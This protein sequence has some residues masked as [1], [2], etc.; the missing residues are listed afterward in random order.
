[1]IGKV[2]ANQRLDDPRRSETQ[3]G[4][5]AFRSEPR[6]EAARL[7]SEREENF[8]RLSEQPG[9]HGLSLWPERLWGSLYLS[10][11]DEIRSKGAW[12]A[13]AARVVFRFGSVCGI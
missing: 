12:F 2:P 7:A 8:L 5:K 13:T 10:P 11:I 1:M 3:V 6:I 9:F 4:E